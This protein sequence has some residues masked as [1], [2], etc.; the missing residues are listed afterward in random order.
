M[1]GRNVRLG[2]PNGARCNTWISAALA[3]ALEVSS[4]AVTHWVPVNCWYT[5][6]RSRFELTARLGFLQL[7]MVRRSADQVWP[8]S[9]ERRTCS[10]QSVPPMPPTRS[11][12]AIQTVFESVGSTAI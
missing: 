10:V 3:Q 4:S 11:H 8:R 7:V 9:V 5:R 6:P 2:V 12:H 1:Y